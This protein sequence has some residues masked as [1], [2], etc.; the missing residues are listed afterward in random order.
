MPATLA[1]APVFVVAVQSYG[2]EAPLRV[3]LFALPWLAFFAAAACGPAQAAKTALGR[4]WRLLAMSVLVG[5]GAFFGYFG[6]EMLNRMAPADVA[7]SRWF[8]D[9]APRE[10]SLTYVAP[11]FPE[12]L[13]A[14]YAYHL[15]AP[16]S[17]VEMPGFRPHRLGARDVHSLESSLRGDDSPQRY[18]VL[19]PSQ[20]R[21]A[22]FYRLLPPGSYAH[23]A[24]ALLASPHF[25]LV[26]R[27]GSA[28]IFLFNPRSPQ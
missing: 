7:A 10:S 25:D 4:S 8:L 15:S 3:F 20:R 5:A 12:R 13:N 2:G 17:L 9:H 14:R 6:Q 18:V 28:L 1:V 21:Y 23:F 11:N 27:R 26:Y 22:R 24:R 16:P 19:S